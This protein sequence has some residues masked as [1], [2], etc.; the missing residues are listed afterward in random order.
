MTQQPLALTAPP[1]KRSKLDTMA[2]YFITH[3]NEWVSALDL[4]R[5]GGLLAWRTRV[6]DCRRVLGMNVENELRRQPDGTQQ[7]FYRYRRKAA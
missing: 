3:E 4:A 1:S 2:G 6:S 5:L 7:S